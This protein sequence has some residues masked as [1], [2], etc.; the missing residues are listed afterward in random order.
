MKTKEFKTIK[1]I[2]G[3]DNYFVDIK[4]NIY[5]TKR[6]T[7]IK[8]STAVRPDGRII[9]VLSKHGKQKSYLVSRLVAEAFLPNPDN[10][11]L[12]AH[13][14][15]NPRDNR[16]DN[17]IWATHSENQLHRVIHGTSNRGERHGR[18]K[19]SAKDVKRIYLD[20]SGATQTTLGSIFGI[21]Q[22]LVS[23]IMTKRVWKWL[24]DQIDKDLSM[25]H[26]TEYIMK[27]EYKDHTDQEG[28]D[29]FGE[30]Y[31]EMVV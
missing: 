4:G 16:V 12:V 20:T 18:A 30:Y 8:M 17:L 31:E 3:Y 26:S 9:A 24:T 27:K 29:I 14:N 1:K 28:Y 19:V 25:G 15:G 23:H 5:S 10:L 7:P 2:A 6:K 21:T 22:Q 11:P 13:I